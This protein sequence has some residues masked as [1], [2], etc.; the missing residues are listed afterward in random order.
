MEKNP[1]LFYSL[2]YIPSPSAELPL[3]SHSRVLFLYLQTPR[4]LSVFDVDFI[5]TYPLLYS[6]IKSSPLYVDQ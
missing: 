2:I 1:L 4:F 5:K 3:S 6:Q